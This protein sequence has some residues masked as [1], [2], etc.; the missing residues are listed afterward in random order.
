MRV[1]R[2]VGV[3]GVTVMDVRLLLWMVVVV[4]I[5]MVVTIAVG[6][7]MMTVLMLVSSTATTVQHMLTVSL[8]L[9]TNLAVD[10]LQEGVL[11]HLIIK[12]V[13]LVGVLIQPWPR[14][15]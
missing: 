1:I 4:L 7:V 3:V 9:K 10:E 6:L 11:V 14:H 12:V 15:L 2:G 13:R 8:E 5:V